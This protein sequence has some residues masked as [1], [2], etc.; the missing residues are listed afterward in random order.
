MQNQGNEEQSSLSRRDFGR[1]TMA[2]FGGVLLGTTMAGSAAEADAKNDPALLL[3]DK[4][5][6]RGLNTCKGKGKGG[7][8]SCAGTGK[9]AI[10]ETHGCK[11]DNA[12]KGQG[13]CGEYAGQNACK[14]QGSCEVPL[15]DKTWKKARKAFE[16]QMKKAGKTVGEAPKKS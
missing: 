12:C 2:V 6:C 13:G 7:D 16:A 5:V 8:N 4:H 3:Q 11:G 1:L 14:G 15:S 10:A 9:C